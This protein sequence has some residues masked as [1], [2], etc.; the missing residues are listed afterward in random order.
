[1]LKRRSNIFLESISDST[2]CGWMSTSIPASLHSLIK[3]LT[4]FLDKRRYLQEKVGRGDK[5]LHVGPDFH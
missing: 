2:I 4:L 5:E 3:V 1:M